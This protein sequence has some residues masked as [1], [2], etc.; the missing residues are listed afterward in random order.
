LDGAVEDSVIVRLNNAFLAVIDQPNDAPVFDGRQEL[1]VRFQQHQ[2]LF[3]RGP[4]NKSSPISASYRAGQNPA[5]G[6]PAD[7][8]SPGDLGFG[9]AGAVELANLTLLKRRRSRA[10]ETLP[11]EPGF[12]Q[13][14]QDAFAEN[15]SL[16]S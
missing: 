10:P 14:G 16:E 13:S 3:W 12:G 2:Q 6:G 9:D 4:Q 1:R 11:V 5:H 15:L 8:E 7:L